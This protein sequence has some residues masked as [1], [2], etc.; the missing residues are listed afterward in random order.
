MNPLVR[1]VKGKDLVTGPMPILLV[2][3]LCFI[4]LSPVYAQKAQ[5]WWQK[6]D[7]FPDVPRITGPEVQ[8]LMLRGER[9]VFVYAGYEVDDVVCGSLY[10]PYT[11]VPPSASG[12]RIKI[13]K[14]PKDWWIMCY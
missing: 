3:I 6:W 12:S 1:F 9:M 14:I 5:K 4:F 8:K 13:K 10:I 2:I 11:L 7:N